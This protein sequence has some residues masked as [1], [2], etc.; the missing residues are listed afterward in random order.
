[1]IEPEIGH[2]FLQLGVRIDVAR[3]A[4]GDEL[5]VDD[6]LRVLKRDDDFALIGS[7]VGDKGEALHGLEGFEKVVEG[8]RLHG[9]RG[10]RDAAGER[11]REP[12]ESATHRREAARRRS[13]AQPPWSD[14]P[15]P[16]WRRWWTERRNQ[17]EVRAPSRVCLR[18]CSVHG[19]VG[20]HCTGRRRICLILLAEIV[21]FFLFLQLLSG[22]DAVDLV[23]VDSMRRAP[24]SGTGSLRS[25][26]W[27]MTALLGKPKEQVFGAPLHSR[28]LGEA[29]IEIGLVEGRR[30]QLLFEPLVDTDG[31]HGLKIAGAWTKGETVERVENS[32]I[33]L[34][35]R[36]VIRGPRRLVGRSLR[37]G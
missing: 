12:R 34:Q 27:R 23:F 26:V 8:L 35:L 20:G 7:E 4:L 32:S 2:H 10:A 21:G 14:W 13:R 16:D 33:T 5:L 15:L 25:I 18:R 19:C 29:G 6:A 36:G 37:N 1:M 31:A 28:E 30:V 22:G 24:R 3:E 11:D 17:V 9:N